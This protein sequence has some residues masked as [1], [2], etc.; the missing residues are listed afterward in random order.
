MPTE[1]RNQTFDQDGNLVAEEIVLVADPLVSDPV[2]QQSLKTMRTMLASF[3]DPA[4]GFPTGTPT[5]NQVRNWLVALTH[6]VA[7]TH[8]ALEELE[9]EP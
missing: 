2:F 1:H 6:G 9:P 4:S 8:E 5:I 7:Y 3:T